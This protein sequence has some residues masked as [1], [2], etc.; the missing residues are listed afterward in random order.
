MN[1]LLLLGG[2]KEAIFALKFIVDTFFIDIGTFLVD[3][4]QAVHLL[5]EDKIDFIKGVRGLTKD[6]V[7]KIL[8]AKTATRSEPPQPIESPLPETAVPQKGDGATS[9]LP[10]S[11][12]AFAA[13]KKAIDEYEKKHMGR[14]NDALPRRMRALLRLLTNEF[15]LTAAEDSPDLSRDRKKAYEEDVPRLKQ[16]FP[17]LPDLPKIHQN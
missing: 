3:K 12:I 17:E 13:W 11:P 1:R 15:Y 5:D 7:D 4:I 16:I 8:A 14:K 6:V 2:Q 10:I 9:A